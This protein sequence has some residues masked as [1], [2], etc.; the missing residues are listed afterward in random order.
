[1]GEFL[2]KQH[3]GFV[4]LSVKR[5]LVLYKQL[6]SGKMHQPGIFMAFPQPCGVL[7]H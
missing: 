5:G 7:T 3:A 1:M 6:I 4:E 2:H